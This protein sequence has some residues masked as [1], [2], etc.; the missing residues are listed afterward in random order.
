MIEAQAKLYGGPA[1]F[2]GEKIT[3]SVTF[4]NIYQDE[5]GQQ[6]SARSECEILAWASA[7]IVCI[8][9]INPQKV[10]DS[11]FGSSTHTTLTTTSLSPSRGE[12]GCV[13]FSTKPKIL[14]CDLSLAAA[15]SAAYK[16][17]ETLPSDLP[18]SFRGQAVKYSYK[19]KIGMQK[20]GSQIKMLHLP[21]RLMTWQTLGLPIYQDE[22]DV[23]VRNPFLKSSPKDS[24]LDQALEAMQLLSS[25]R[26]PSVYKV[27][28][29]QGKVVS[30]CLFKSSYRLGED[31]IGTLDFS[32]GV[33]SCMQYSVT[34][35]SQE[36]VPEEKRRRLGNAAPTAEETTIVSHTKHHEFSVGFLQTHMSLPVPLYVTPSFDTDL[37]VLKWRLH[38]EFVTAVKAIDWKGE[39]QWQPPQVTDIETMVWDFPIVIYPTAPAHVSK[40]FYSQ[41]DATMA[42]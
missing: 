28:N 18:P 40:A 5:L 41:R 13:I 3:C 34:L 22:E 39:S 19:L 23:A 17:E 42:I 11:T 38:F 27:T 30:L 8:C 33:V 31:I 14:V 12:H 36:I 4:R 32:D 25:R 6:Q 21:L 7:Q 10:T 37:I 24:Q 1:F 20:V 26:S 2:A 35:Q 29:S 16:Y 15:Q 9:S